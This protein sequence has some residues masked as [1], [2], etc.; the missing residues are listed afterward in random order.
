MTGI[1]LYKQNTGLLSMYFTLT[2]QVSCLDSAFCHAKQYAEIINHSIDLR[3]LTFQFKLIT[4]YDK[5]Y[6]GYL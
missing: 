5:T 4:S 3:K 2:R 6:Q 1:F